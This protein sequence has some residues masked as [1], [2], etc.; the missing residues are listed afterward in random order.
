MNKI[1]ILFFL[2]LLAACGTTSNNEQTAFNTDILLKQANELMWLHNNYDSAKT[3]YEYILKQ[4]PANEAANDGIIEIMIQKENYSIAMELTDSLMS[5]N[6]NNYW[7][8]LIKGRITEKTTSVDSAIHFYK[9]FLISSGDT[10]WRYTPSLVAITEKRKLTAEELEYYGIDAITYKNE[11]INYSNGGW[12]EIHDYKHDTVLFYKT[13]LLSF[14]IDT[15]LIN[16]G[17]NYVGI[18][19]GESGGLK[20]YLKEKFVERATEFGLTSLPT[21]VE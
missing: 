6:S 5:I 4:E 14:Q 8:N 17:I 11:L 1:F 7:Y 16:N 20:V 2:L 19:G 13:D 10:I 9:Q 3:I 15:I 12:T 18:A 21:T